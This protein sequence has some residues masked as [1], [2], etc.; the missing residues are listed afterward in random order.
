MYLNNTK[1]L[2]KISSHLLEIYRYIKRL[3]DIASVQ[4][5]P[6]FIFFWARVKEL[7]RLLDLVIN[8]EISELFSDI[9][10]VQLF[11]G[12]IFLMIFTILLPFR[13][14]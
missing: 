9:G 7:K 14:I 12:F 11:S 2:Q 1:L 6:G 3:M 5:F 10:S 8:Y 4:L 13:Y